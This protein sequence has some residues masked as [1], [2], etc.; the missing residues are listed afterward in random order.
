[1]LVLDLRNLPSIEVIAYMSEE[2]RIECLD[3]SSLVFKH[4]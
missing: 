1:M 2:W 3:A 4:A